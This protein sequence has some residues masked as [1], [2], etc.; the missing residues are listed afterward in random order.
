MTCVPAGMVIPPTVI[1]GSVLVVT[2]IR[3]GVKPMQCLVNYGWNIL[4]R[5]IS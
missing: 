2:A 3:E 5:F 1:K 4:M